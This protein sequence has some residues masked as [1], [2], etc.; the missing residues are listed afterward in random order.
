MGQ[1]LVLYMNNHN[2][3]VCVYNRAAF[4][5]STQII[6]A[7][8]IEEL[9]LKLKRPRKILLLIESGTVVDSF[10]ELLLPYINQDDDNSYFLD[11]IHMNGIVFVGSGVLVSEKDLSLMPGNG[12]SKIWSIQPTF[13]AIAA[14]ALDVSPYYDWTINKSR[15]GRYIKM[16][17]TSIGDI[18]L[19]CKIYLHIIKDVEEITATFE[20]WNRDELDS[21]C[22]E[23]IRDI[24]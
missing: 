1:I 11:S 21:F 22:I 4:Q 23:I 20:D 13:Q 12:H 6:S 24:L 10:I 5:N 8:C 16:D 2:F 9:C 17:H 19:I 18:Q 3:T 14:K 15:T 7:Y